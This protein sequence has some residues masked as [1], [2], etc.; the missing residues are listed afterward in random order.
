ML[1]I[2]NRFLEEIKREKRRMVAK[3]KG[4]QNK[5]VRRSGS[6]EG[7][8]GGKGEKQRGC[9]RKTPFLVFLVRGRD[10]GRI[11]WLHGPF[12]GNSKEVGLRKRKR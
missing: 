1:A 12:W 4:Q 8:K 2:E 3:K 6:T 10:G 5:K 7:E 9:C 11:I